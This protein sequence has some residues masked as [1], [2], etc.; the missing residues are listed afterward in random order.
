[1]GT[2]DSHGD[3]PGQIRI[4]GE[5]IT[6]S[7][8]RTGD[9]TGTLTWNIPAP[10]AGCTSENQ[11]YNGIVIVGN[12]VANGTQHWP[13]EGTVYTGDPTLDSDLHAGSEIN[14][15]LVVGAF[16]NDKTT[17]TLEVS[18][19]QANTAYFFTAH[20][21]DNVNR[22]HKQGV[23]TYA[24]PYLYRNA[25]PD[26][27][28][29]HEITFDANISGSNSTGLVATQTYTLNLTVDGVPYE[30]T[31]RGS[32]SLTFGALVDEI[33]YQLQFAENPFQSSE[34]PNAGSYWYADSKLYQWNGQT[35]VEIS[36]I[37]DDTD[38]TDVD[39]GEYW[40]DTANDLLYLRSAGAWT[41]VTPVE[42]GFDPA[43]PVDSGFWM[44]TNGSPNEVPF[45]AWQWEGTTWC[46]RTLVAQS[47]DPSCAPE[48]TAGTYWYNESTMILH[49]WNTTLERWDQTEGIAWDTDPRNPALG[50]FWFNDADNELF[51][52]T[53]STT[54][55]QR[56]VLVQSTQPSS[57]Y[58]N[59]TYWWDTINQIL[60]VKQAGSPLWAP[61]D[62][63]VWGSD[64]T[65]P[66]SC[67]LWWDLSSSPQQLKKWDAVNIE[68]D[69]V[70]SFT[71]STTDPSLPTLPST[72]TIWVQTGV[73]PL[74]YWEWDGSQFVQIPSSNYIVSINDPTAVVDGD[75]WH[76]TVNDVY[77]ELALSVWTTI[78]V[79]RTSQDPTLLATGTF[80]F[81]TATSTLSMWNGA[82]WVTIMYSTT[83]LYPSDG[84]L[85]FNTAVGCDTSETLLVW[86]STTLTWETATPI[87]TATLNSSRGT[88]KPNGNIV[89]ETTTAGS[90]GGIIV[91]ERR[92]E[93]STFD[94]VGYTLTG[95]MWSSLDPRI[96]SA[97][98]NVVGVDGLSGEQSYDRVGV[99]TDGSADERRE[100]S[101]SIRRQLGHPT[102]TVEL[103]KEQLDTAI[104]K[105]IEALRQRSA[106][107]Y[108]R[109]YFFMD[110]K[111]GVQRYLL[112]NERAGFHK[113]VNIMGVWRITSAFLS[114][115]H[116]AGVYGQTI[117]QHLYH[118]GT[119]DL[120]S[121]HLISD[122]I[123]QLEQLFA[124]RVTYTWDEGSREF[125]MFQRITRDERVLLD[126]VIER[127]EQ[128]LMTN[129]Y[130]KK[131]IERWALGEAKLML[132]Q[133]RGKY[134]TLP[135][136]GGGVALNAGDLTASA[137]EDFIR[138]DAEI[139]DFVVN[140]VENLGIG[141]ELI[142][143]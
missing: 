11:A 122:Y 78:D 8:E 20:A 100:L 22:Y 5:N 58:A 49:E 28:S 3:V 56:A 38:P 9:A 13:V 92:V 17:T 43:D 30:L 68:W 27:S 74:V 139:D 46:Q 138:C 55:T 118:M 117:L 110:A 76:D 113:I 1:M 24:L 88:C 89:F 33:N 93:M 126:S 143:G 19:L 136:A 70:T 109:V 26:Q 51:E 101:D 29:Y 4:E 98:P 128:E 140:D 35:N 131:W 25:T 79:T 72:G 42:S 115:V 81:D 32:E 75:V 7:F 127:T 82:A 86:N 6:I 87:A 123:E 73:N 120:V 105:A 47:K 85:W 133:I 116:A 69:I 41:L 54:W 106:S 142:I 23:S 104:E 67:D 77:Y 37:N 112:T 62:A 121:Y 83:P 107:A 2:F 111:P 31:I 95:T 15:A 108:R 66:T 135:G 21:V 125:T 16:Y 103:D 40:L 96:A 59:G 97:Q 34:G 14:D 64:P 50:T 48:L 80:W 94:S 12:T 63:I 45:R 114:T 141:S 39:N 61:I 10:A 134:A 132:A 124:T 44:E 99:G 84:D 60:H 53:N 71:I 130:T 91:G 57:A 129:R 119:Y 102:I 90:E 137:Q 52:R 65:S 36:V 18:G